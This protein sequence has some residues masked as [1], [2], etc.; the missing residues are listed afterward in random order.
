MLV[1]RHVPLLAE[2]VPLIA[3]PAIRNRGTIGGSL[4]FADPA[5]E[6]PAC[7]VALDATIVARS[8]A[9][10]RRIPAAQ[11]FTGLYATALAPNEL[12]AAVEFPVAKPGERSVILE[13]ARRSGDYAMAGVAAKAQL[14]GGALVEPRLVFFGVGDG[15][16]A[17]RAGDGA[18]SPASPRRRRRSPRRRPRSTPIS[19]RPP[20]CTAA[21][22]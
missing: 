1:R 17:G 2:A 7:C 20:T 22:R 19:T 8:A 18:P 15:A 6:L 10:E 16:G 5:A 21:R 14:D 3:H 12:I 4:A 9:G 13:L 11:F